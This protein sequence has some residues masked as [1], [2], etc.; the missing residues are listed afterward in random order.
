MTANPVF[1]ALGLPEAVRRFADEEKGLIVFSGADTELVN[2]SAQALAR[3]VAERTGRDSAV[4][5]SHRPAEGHGIAA[6]DAD[7]LIQAVDAAWGGAL[8]ITTLPFSGNAYVRLLD[9]LQSTDDWEIRPKFDAVL[10]AVVQPAEPDTGDEA[11]VFIPGFLRR[12]D[13]SAP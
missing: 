10:Y 9:L 4:V 2:S 6:G 1:E 12:T 5:G 11:D 3:Y 7:A 8:V 13:L